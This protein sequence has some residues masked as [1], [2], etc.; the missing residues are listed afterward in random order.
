MN[1]QSHYDLEAEKDRLG[2]A[3]EEEVNVFAG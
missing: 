1:L 2:R 3:L